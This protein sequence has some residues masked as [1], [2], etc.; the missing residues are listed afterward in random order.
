MSAE[1]IWYAMNIEVTSKR[2]LKP[3]PVPVQLLSKDTI[4]WN[5]ILYSLPGIKV[6]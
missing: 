3:Y 6:S 4:I 5:V 2:E 1:Y